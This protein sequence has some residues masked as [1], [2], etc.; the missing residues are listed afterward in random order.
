MQEL[1][2]WIHDAEM[3]VID[4]VQ[5]VVAV[6]VAAGVAMNYSILNYHGSVTAATSIDSMVRSH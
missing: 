6:A 2:H 3:R 5:G 1:C 4:E